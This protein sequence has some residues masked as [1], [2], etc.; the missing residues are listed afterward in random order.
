MRN[1]IANR[2]ALGLF[3]IADENS[4][5]EDIM[6][7]CQSL[8]DVFDQNE[9]LEEVLANPKISKESKLEIFEQGIKGHI[10]QFTYDFI[11]LTI[12][13]GRV[14]HLKQSLIRF[15]ELSNVAKGLINVEVTSATQLNPEQIEKL[16]GQLEKSTSKKININSFIDPE[17]IGGLIIKVGN[18][19][20]DGSIKN[21][22]NKIRES[23]LKAQVTEVE[24]R[25]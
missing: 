25:E 9:S 22:I 13:K 5:I 11:C 4:L 6:S 14:S 1:T 20:I 16:Q 23:L 8:I 21:Q 19:V 12:D 7:D 10:H 17:I 15:I 24:V 3:K 18:N 2:Y